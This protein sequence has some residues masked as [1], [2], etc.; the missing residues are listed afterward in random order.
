KHVDLGGA[1]A[2]V[3]GGTGPVGQRAVRLLAKQGA[4][5]RVC[6]RSKER[7]QDICNEIKSKTPGAQL[8]ALRCASTSDTAA[9]LEGT[10]ILIAAGAAGVELVSADVR[11]AAR[12]L[13]V[14]IDLNAVPP[15]GIAGVESMDKAKER[16]GLIC[17]GAIGVGGTKMKIHRAA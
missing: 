10:Q 7:A 14:A 5:V 12:S 9:A 2:T 15:I 11:R 8:T 16:D 3:L 4:T 13:K 6:S 1:A 17:Y